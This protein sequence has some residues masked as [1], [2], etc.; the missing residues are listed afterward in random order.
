MLKR[1][2]L[3]IVIGIFLFSQLSVCAKE[4][5]F[6]SAMSTV[7]DYYN[8]KKYK[9][10]LNL[11]KKIKNEELTDEEKKILEDYMGLI[12]MHKQFDDVAKKFVVSYDKYENLY[13]YYPRFVLYSS[14]TPYI[15]V[16]K[17][18]KNIQYYIKFT[19]YHNSK[20]RI[21]PKEVVLNSDGQ[22]F[23][24]KV[25]SGSDECTDYKTYL[26]KT[27]AMTPITDKQR[28]ILDVIM[29]GSNVS[30]IIRES[31]SSLRA[32]SQITSYEYQ[33]IDDSLK[34]YT[35]LKLKILKLGENRV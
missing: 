1:I 33:L 19:A 21:T 24:F 28:T 8:A 18:G 6:E 16:D 27:I 9:K 35:A 14:V 10:A 26:R 29:Q 31:S 25:A 15:T 20:H 23:I 13:T 11:C 17:D 2:G 3:F 12:L 4:F 30:F 34:L 32:E 5:S 22:N 7:H